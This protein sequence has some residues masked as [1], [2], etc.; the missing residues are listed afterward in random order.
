IKLPVV[1]SDISPFKEVGGNEVC[2]FELSE[3]PE[4]IA[5]KILNLLSI[6]KSNRFFRRVIKDYTWDNIYKEK[7]LPLLTE[8]KERA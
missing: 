2:F 4:E 1:C 8:I 7:L 5:E 3:T 6:R